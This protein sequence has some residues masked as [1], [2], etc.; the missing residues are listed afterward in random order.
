L[1]DPRNL[2]VK[3]LPID[4][5]F[6]TQDLYALFSEYGTI[7]SA[8]VMMDEVNWVSKGFGFVSFRD[9]EEARVAMEALNG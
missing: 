3:N 8:K 6:D 2:Y 7:V 4:P 1:L 9:E 5:I